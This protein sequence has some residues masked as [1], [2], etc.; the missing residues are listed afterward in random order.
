M[1]D[2]ESDSKVFL[3]VI[4]NRKDKLIN[5]L[6]SHSFVIEDISLDHPTGDAT[7]MIRK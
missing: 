6:C 5:L 1:D 2:N 4:M 3:K 7:E